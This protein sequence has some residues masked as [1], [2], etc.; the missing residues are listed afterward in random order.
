MYILSSEGPQRPKGLERLGGLGFLSLEMV[1]YIIIYH[2]HITVYQ[3]LMGGSEEGGTSL[4]PA[5]PT[6]RTRG[7]GTS[8]NTGNLNRWRDF[9]IRMV[10]QWNR[11]PMG[12]QC[13]GA[14]QNRTGHGL[15]NQLWAELGRRSPELPSNSNYSVTSWVWGKETLSYTVRKPNILILLH[16]L[17]MFVGFSSY[18]TRINTKLWNTSFWS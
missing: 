2:T 4:F 9:P 1:Q 12:L 5:V 14:V 3:V 8:W 7:N 16:M 18:Q 13:L 10:R 6:D 17:I 15:S 11:L